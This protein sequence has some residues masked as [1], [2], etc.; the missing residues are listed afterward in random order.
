[1]FKKYKPSKWLSYLYF[2]FPLFLV[3]KINIGKESDIW[4]LLSYGK[5]IITSGFPK[6][7]FLSMHENFSFVMQQW[8]SAIIFAVI[9][10]I[11]GNL[12][13]S[14]F[15]TSLFTVIIYLFYKLC[16][17][18]S[19]NKYYLSLFLTL[20]FSLI[21][22]PIFITSRPQVISFVI[23][24][25]YFNLLERYVK[26]NKTKYL[27]PL[28]ILSLLEI[29]LHG[30]LF[31][32]LPC[33][34]FPYIVEGILKEFS[35]FTKDKYK[36][37]PLLITFILVLLTG[38]INPYGTDMLT[39]TYKALNNPY[40][41]YFVTEVKPP[42]IKET[43][44][45][46]VYLTI[47]A[48]LICYYFSKRKI[49]IRYFLLYLGTTI[50][51]ICSIRNYCYLLIAGLFPLADYYKDR[52]RSYKKVNLTKIDKLMVIIVTCFYLIIICNIVVIKPDKH[53]LEKVVNYL[54][55]H[56]TKDVLLYNDFNEGS[57]LEFNG[58]KTYIDPRPEMFLK[59]I[60]RQEDILKEYYNLQTGNL[61]IKDFLAKYKFTYLVLSDS[62]VM[63]YKEEELIDYKLVY[64]EKNYKIYIRK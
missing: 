33:F 15:I 59:S 5:K 50:L 11:G 6:Y 55:S 24:L 28:P 12:G 48:I 4:F 21:M 37:G 7:D 52:A 14:I 63:F 29:N 19:D 16:S 38:F 56:T 23:Y 64:S 46:I 13:I 26:T 40:L 58:Y 18:V 3:T 57:Y 39:Y 43:S 27:I 34:I 20:L 36:V 44:G 61:K 42:S 60:N 10:N 32:I 54:D 53:P 17:C 47:F 51:T 9:Y 41:K 62:D 25:L 30:S 35:C 8:L 49:K 22:L 45:L 31:F 2:I 1:M